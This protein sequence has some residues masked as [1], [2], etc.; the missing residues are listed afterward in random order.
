MNTVKPQSV[1]GDPSAVARRVESI[2]DILQ[3][4]GQYERFP[5]PPG[6]E[7]AEQLQISF[8]QT[9][10]DVRMLGETQLLVSLGFRCVI[11]THDSDLE[12]LAS[13]DFGREAPAGLRFRAE[14]AY[15]VSYMISAGTAPTREE[16]EAFGQ[17]NVPLNIVPYWREF[18]DSSLRRA[19]M[20]PVMAPVHKTDPASRA[21]E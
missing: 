13:S 2:N 10:P 11:A 19:G 17:V 7:A 6:S 20:P 16:L 21:R 18:L 15:V 8:S 12:A 14:A 3:V 9:P 5:V 4:L 1:H